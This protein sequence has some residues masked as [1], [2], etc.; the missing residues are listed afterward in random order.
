MEN[1]IASVL[2]TINPREIQDL[3]LNLI[4]MSLS[5]ILVSTLYFLGI[6]LHDIDVA[7]TEAK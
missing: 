5:V 1:E 6:S 4:C 7:T 3:P 2:A